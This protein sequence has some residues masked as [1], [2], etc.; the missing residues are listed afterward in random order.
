[1]KT[2]TT[3]EPKPESKEVTKLMIDR[4]SDFRFHA[5]YLAYSE[6]WNKTASEE[7]KTKMNEIMLSLTKNEISYSNFYKE[8]GQYREQSSK[9]Y[10][11]RRIHTQRKRKWRKRRA[12]EIRNAR[13]KRRH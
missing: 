5:A 1:M 8:L 6:T 7:I 4:P 3:E 2:E 10:A 13:H 12:K 11:R 9:Y